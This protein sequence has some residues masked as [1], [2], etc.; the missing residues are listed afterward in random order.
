MGTR[1]TVAIAVKLGLSVGVGVGVGGNVGNVVGVT[2][3]MIDVGRMDCILFGISMDGGY[4]FK[5][6][7]FSL[8]SS[9]HQAVMI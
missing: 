7:M 6:G 3:G 4:F 1:V 8:C 5:V 9:N 2:V